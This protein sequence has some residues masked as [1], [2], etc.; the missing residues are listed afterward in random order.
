MKKIII[1]EKIK[2]YRKEKRITQAEFGE[3]L[4][5]SAQA[6]SKWESELCYPDITFLPDIAKILGCVIDDLFAA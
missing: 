5:V 4:G 6:V 3:I 2:K 1:C